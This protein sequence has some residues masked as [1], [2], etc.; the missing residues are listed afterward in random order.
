[1]IRR[2]PFEQV[3]YLLSLMNLERMSKGDVIVRQDEA[4]D[5]QSKMYIVRSGLMCIYAQGDLVRRPPSRTG[6]LPCM[7]CRALPLP[8]APAPPAARPA[9]CAAALHLRLPPVNPTLTHL[10]S[11][12]RRSSNGASLTLGKSRP[13][14]PSADAEFGVAIGNVGPGQAVGEFAMI[15]GSPRTASVVCSEPGEIFTVSRWAMGGLWTGKKGGE[16]GCLAAAA[17]AAATPRRRAV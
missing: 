2:T 7:G 17:A 4:V 1:M 5:M 14:E 13:R 10:Q 12:I 15:T 16:G 8:S 3:P 6:G 11:A 9:C